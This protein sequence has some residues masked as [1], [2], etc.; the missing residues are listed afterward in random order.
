V[1]QSK[2]I[3][4]I[5]KCLALAQSSNP[6]EAAT[7]FRQAHALMDKYGIT[8]RQAAISDIT[9]M[10]V[11]GDH[12]SR[13]PLWAILLVKTCAYAFQCEVVFK[14]SK[15]GCS[16]SFYGTEQDVDLAAYA[17]EQLSRAHQNARKAFEA[18]I[19]H[20][21]S[22]YKRMELKSFSMGWSR[23]VSKSISDFAAQFRE[24]PQFALIHEAIQQQVQV[25]SKKISAPAK[26]TQNGYSAG[27]TEGAKVSIRNGLGARDGRLAL[28]NQ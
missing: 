26:M 8:E 1:E 2:V 3:D 4:K 16:Y 28:T 17:Y 23:A 21:N 5:K 24:T 14:G 25:K 9:V 11:M 20:L 19:S 22:K 10:E 7:A 13:I 18:S 27:R 12:K 15:N 6:N